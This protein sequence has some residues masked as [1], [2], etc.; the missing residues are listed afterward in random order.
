MKRMFIATI[1]AV[2]LL[3]AA[4][5]FPSK[6][7]LIK[8]TGTVR[9]E[10]VVLCS[11]A[12]AAGNFGAN[13]NGTLILPTGPV[14]VAAVVRVT[15]DSTGTLSFTEAR[16]IGGSFAN[17]TATGPWIRTAQEQR[18]F[19]SSSR[20]SSSAHQL[21]LWCLTITRENFGSFKNRSRCRM[22][23]TFRLSYPV[24]AERCERCFGSVRHSQ[25]LARLCAESVDV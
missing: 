23:Q 3:M 9:A 22:A 19:K 10:E 25:G 2:L 8:A 7:P 18:R 16:S 12:S 5:F 4:G 6:A 17:E 14:P 24:R 13:L 21:L 20:D 11:L 1:P 15:A